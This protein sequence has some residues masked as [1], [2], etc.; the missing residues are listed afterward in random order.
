MSKILL[1]I[2]DYAAPYKGNFI[3]SL[4]Y[5]E[6]N[7]EV[8]NIY[9]FPNR[10]KNN[11]AYEWIKSL[12]DTETV[13]YIQ[14]ENWMKNLLLIKKIIE[15]HSVDYVFRHFYD[16]KI[17][18]ILKV[19]FR[20][21]KIIRFFHCMYDNNSLN[22]IKHFSRK[23]IWKNNILVGVSKATSRTLKQAF[24]NFS[25]KTVENAI[26]F[27]RLNVV[28]ASE[29]KNKISLMVMG[30]N[31]KVKGVDI[32]LKV[33]DRLR[34]EYD[35]LLRIVAPSNEKHLVSFINDIYGGMPE[36]VELLPPTNNIATYYNNTD[37]FL[38]PSRTEA[39]GYAVVEAAYCK[40]SIVA[41][42]VEGQGEL[43][44]NG[45]Y[46][47]KSEDIDDFSLKLELAIQQLHSS[48]KTSQKEKVFEDVQ[49]L[50]SLERW[51]KEIIEIVQ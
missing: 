4:Q 49:N 11:S 45:V 13:A 42:D 25:V 32:A 50:Y 7:G 18:L 10:A 5:L 40:N 21:K 27:T 28:N 46:W 6:K 9:I 37:I 44:I 35:L 17:D 30:Y 12:N 15:K 1:H 19:L 20:S 16:I 43:E 33:V 3:N 14:E 31:I 8:K 24:N 22:K 48:E 29:K 26:D 39:F 51:K 47:F 34:K 36:W 38:S 2:C 41:S 23:V